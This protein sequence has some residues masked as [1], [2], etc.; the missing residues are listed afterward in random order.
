[1]YGTSVRADWSKKARLA[2]GATGWRMTMLD[3]PSVTRMTRAT[4]REV[5]LKPIMGIKILI[6][7]GYTMLRKTIHIGLATEE[8]HMAKIL[9]ASLPA[10][11]TRR[12]N[13]SIGQG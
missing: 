6:M 8:Q 10:K 1:M 7:T 9:G 4:Q 11:A 2:R 13:N 12:D 5:Y 3:T